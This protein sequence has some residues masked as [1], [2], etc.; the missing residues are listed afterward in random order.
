MF[1]LLAAAFAAPPI[2]H[3]PP[4]MPSPP[5][6]RVGLQQPVA[7]ASIPRSSGTSPTTPSPRGT[8]SR[9]RRVIARPSL[10]PSLPWSPPRPSTPDRKISNG[11][12]RR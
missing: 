4:V 2:V 5:V 9:G 12:A 7:G 11:M 3:S 8:A 10:V 1:A 6:Q